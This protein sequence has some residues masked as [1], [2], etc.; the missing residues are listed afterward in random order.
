V[1]VGL[2]VLWLLL[3][4]G[5]VLAQLQTGPGRPAGGEQRLADAE[6]T[7]T[8]LAPVGW[9]DTETGPWAVGGREVGVYVAAA[10]NLSAFYRM[11]GP[12]VFIGASAPLAQSLGVA[13]LLAAERASAA[14]RC[15]HA[16]SSSYGDRFYAGSSEAFDACGGGPD[17]LVTATL[18]QG[19]RYLVLV[20]AAAASPADRA[21]IQRVLATFQVM[22]QPGADRHGD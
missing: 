15:R 3:P 8:A 2:V 20:R 5:L 11:D 21:A 10:P 17:R 13:G 4:G 1:L 18:G 19:G 6:E 14:G 12:G 22:G 16:G 9:A 7:L